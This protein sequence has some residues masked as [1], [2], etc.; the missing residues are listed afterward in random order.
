MKIDI[1]VDTV[2]PWCYVGK[3]RFDRALEMRPQTEIEVGW[4]PF[5]LNPGMPDGGMD[6]RQYVN[7]KF[8]GPDRAR[9]VHNSI[10]RIGLEEGIKFNFKGISRIPNTIN[11]HRLS[12]FAAERG[13]QTQAIAAIFAAYF[14]DGRDI[15]EIDVLADVAAAIGLDRDEAQ[16]YLASDRDVETILAEDE[17]ARR[18]GV[19]GVPCFIVNRRY[20]VSGAQAPEVLIQ[21]FDLAYQDE[22]E[23]SVS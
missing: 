1:V 4:R 14:H 8:G 18:L 13:Y 17:L 9:M 7:E 12:R 16:A 21:V 2:C 20:A 23:L 3:K 6:R 19:N 15:G 10:S 22:L 11:S 5:Q